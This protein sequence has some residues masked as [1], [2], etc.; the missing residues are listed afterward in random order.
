MAVCGLVNAA[1]KKILKN[2]I[3]SVGFDECGGVA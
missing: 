3:K 1:A 2:S